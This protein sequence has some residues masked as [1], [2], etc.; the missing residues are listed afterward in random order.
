[1]PPL[2]ELCESLRR[3]QVRHQLTPILYLKTASLVALKELIRVCV[4]ELQSQPFGIQKRTSVNNTT[5]RWTYVKTDLDFC[6]IV[7]PL[8]KHEHYSAHN[9]KE[10]WQ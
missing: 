7:S 5:R 9:N 1:M 3:R 10:L 4:A 8:S 6:R 2:S